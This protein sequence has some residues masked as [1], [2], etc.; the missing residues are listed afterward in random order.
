MGR[1]PAHT[2]DD[3]IDAAVRLFAAGGARAV[4]M[5][6][7]AREVG[8]PSGSV[9]HRFADRPAL[10]SAI[11]LRTV[12]RFQEDWLAAVDIEPAM[13]AAIA[14]ATRTVDWCREHVDEA[15]VLYAGKRAFSCETWS[16]GAHEELT[17]N[18][19]SRDRLLGRMLRRVAAE[20][21]RS[22]EEVS[23][24]VIDLPYAVCRRYLVN[25][26]GPP[27]R[28]TDLVARTARMILLG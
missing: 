3:F 5:S 20:T 25:G 15:I 23:L 7:V 4:T 13:D 22:L 8:A 2:A 6:S 14:A 19:A 26:Q 9:Y 27:E 21:E 10:L 11:W 18:D 24:A 28:A 16:A 12:R 17:A 1:P